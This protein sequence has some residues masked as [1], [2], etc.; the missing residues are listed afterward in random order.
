MSKRSLVLLSVLV[1]VGLLAAASVYAYPR[2][3]QWYDAVVQGEV[4][5]VDFTQVPIADGSAEVQWAVRIPW[6]KDGLGGADEYLGER[7]L[8]VPVAAAAP[9][10]VCVGPGPRIAVE[11]RGFTRVY[12]KEGEFLW[13]CPGMGIGFLADGNL[14][15]RGGPLRLVDSGGNL[16]W[17][18]EPNDITVA[19]LGLEDKR[20]QGLLR[21]SSSCYVSGSA[22][23]WCDDIE[24]GKIVTVPSSSAPG[25]T[26][27]TWETVDQF[28]MGM[29][30]DETGAVKLCKN[31]SI[32]IGM[33]FTPQGTAFGHSDPVENGYAIKE[34]SVDRYPFRVKRIVVMKRGGIVAAGE[35]GSLVGY[36]FAIPD[37]MAFIV[38]RQGADRAVRFRLPEGEYSIE[39]QLPTAGLCTRELT[40]E[41]LEVTCW[42]WP[43]P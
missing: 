10:S 42:A 43:T 17:A 36:D 41:A 14:V 13:S 27:E 30:F 25:Q 37:P 39:T 21:G 18:I 20:K 23:Y 16:L 15:T 32:P 3:A 12:N 22:I 24:V 1:G 4:E 28:S 26:M 33:H 6:S 34:I 19:T 29:V 8:G 31:D 7:D 40:R 2:A 35:D 9:V 5:T 11:D 38:Y